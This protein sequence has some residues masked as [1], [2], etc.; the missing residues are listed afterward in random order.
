MQIVDSFQTMI[1]LLNDIRLSLNTLIFLIF[2][3][4][5]LHIAVAKNTR[6]DAPLRKPGIFSRLWQKMKRG[7]K[8]PRGEKKELTE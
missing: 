1:E 6:P 5:I 8:L 4:I 3:N 2:I 7:P